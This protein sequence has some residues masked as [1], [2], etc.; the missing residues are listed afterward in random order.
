MMKTKQDDFTIF[1]RKIAVHFFGSALLSVAVVISLYFFLW[2]E[3]LGDWIVLFLEII[4]KM[5]HEKAFSIYHSVFREYREIFFFAVAIVIIFLIL[6]LFLF[7]WLTKYFRE[8]N[9]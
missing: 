5:D 3:R 6:L 1:Q 4:G 8:I 2:K 7:R 9:R